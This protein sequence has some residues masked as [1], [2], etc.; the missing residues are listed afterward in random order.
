MVPNPKIAFTGHRPN[1]IGGYDPMSDQRLAI[2]NIIDQVIDRF[3][4][5][6]MCS[7]TVTIISG[8]AQG[9]DQDVVRSALRLRRSVADVQDHY[10][11]L[12]I[13]AALPCL[14]QDRPWPQPSRDAYQALLAQCDTMCYVTADDYTPAC[15][16]RR[17][18]YMVNMADYVVAFWDGSKGGTGSTVAYA[19][20]LEKPVF[21]FNPKDIWNDAESVFETLYSIQ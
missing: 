14:H 7:E 4:G 15:M 6:A 16:F 17:N 18:Q 8:M 2:S 21:A 11:R 1:K 5:P 13:H 9:I 19:E 12:H 10:P 20:S 3:F